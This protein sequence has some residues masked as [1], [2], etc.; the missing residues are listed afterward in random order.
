MGLAVRLNPG[1]ISLFQ[2]LPLCFDEYERPS[3]PPSHSTPLLSK[4]STMQASLAICSLALAS[5]ASSV[6]AFVAPSAFSGKAL[7]AAATKSAGAVVRMSV[8]Q[9]IGAVRNQRW[10]GEDGQSPPRACCIPLMLFMRASLS[11]RM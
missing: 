1:Q 10:S 6:S 9:M 7:S 2:L 3:L 11:L 5:M 8:D 4:P